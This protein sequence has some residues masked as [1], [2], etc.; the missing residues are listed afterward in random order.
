MITVPLQVGLEAQTQVPMTVNAG[1]PVA[2]GLG[3]LFNPTIN[4][5]QYNTTAGWAEHPEYIP[6]QGAIIVYSDYATVD[7]A[8][9]PN[10]KVGDGTTYVVDLPFVADDLRAL[11]AEHISDSAIH[12]SAADRAFWDNKVTCD[13]AALNASDYELIFSKE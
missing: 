8:N 3:A 13:V 5:I 7:E 1:G 4:D 11:L 2:L 10:I 6:E 9:V 12:V